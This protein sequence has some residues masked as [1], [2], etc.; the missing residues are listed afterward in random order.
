MLFSPIFFQEFILHIDASDIQLGTI[1]SQ[2]FGREHPFFYLSR[3]SFPREK[4]YSVIE[5]EALAI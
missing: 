4:A 2:D 1:F 3:I 5:K